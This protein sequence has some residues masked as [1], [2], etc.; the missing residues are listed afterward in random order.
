M[1]RE[2]CPKPV[3]EHGNIVYV[4]YVRQHVDLFFRKELCLIDDDRCY[5]MAL[6]SD[7]GSAS[8]L[9]HISKEFIHEHALCLKTDS[10]P[11]DGLSVSGVG[12]RF[13]QDR[14]LILFNVIVS[15]HQRV[16]G[17]GGAHCAVSEIESCHVFVLSY[18]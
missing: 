15:D 8:R 3:A 11:H 16:G 1:A 12:P 14:M 5:V 13:Q 17:L 6:Q 10:R 9:W 7:P 18:T 4:H 2:V